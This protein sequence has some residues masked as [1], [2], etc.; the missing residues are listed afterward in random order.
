M[1]TYEKIYNA[2]N[3]VYKFQFVSPAEQNFTFDVTGFGGIEYG[4]E[5]P[6]NEDVLYPSTIEIKIDDYDNINYV[7]LFNLRAS[8]FDNMN[9]F[10]FDFE[11]RFHLKV[12]KDNVQIYFGKL[13]SIEKELK[14]EEV[15][16]TFSD[17]LTILKGLSWWN[18]SVSDYLADSA[19]EIG[20]EAHILERESVNVMIGLEQTTIPNAVGF[21]C[22]YRFDKPDP[23]I[24]QWYLFRD[25]SPEGR[26]C[27]FGF[28]QFLHTLYK[29]LRSSITFSFYHSWQVDP[30]GSI[31][32]ISNIENNRFR[33]ANLAEKIFGYYII[34]PKTDREQSQVPLNV[35]M[36]YFELKQTMTING[37]EYETWADKEDK[38]E[39]PAREKYDY[40]INNVLKHLAGC[41]YAKTGIL[42]LNQAYFIQKNYSAS[43]T[44]EYI[45]LDEEA[46][47]AEIRTDDPCFDRVCVKSIDL[48]RPDEHTEGTG[49]NVKTYEIDYDLQSDEG[50]AWNN[51]A[52]L[53]QDNFLYGFDSVNGQ[54]FYG[55]NTTSAVMLSEYYYDNNTSESRLWNIKLER[56]DQNFID[57]LKLYKILSV[58]NQFDYTHKIRPITMKKEFINNKTIIEGKE[59][60]FE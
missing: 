44:T 14:D 42:D 49:A 3:G 30:Q 56:V 41:F 20:S 35:W 47:N 2:V 1:A 22:F 51:F 29:L 39:V 32:G 45:V 25:M 43:P 40:K 19:D 23:N 10:P 12:F 5:D 46:E 13:E 34:I 27:N 57:V 4:Y 36:E 21:N 48:D 33:I 6:N 54:G 58:N 17:G 15:T 50:V 8:Y 11:S 16:L 37:T 9:T 38:R 24:N 31:G 52:W 60:L 18:K 55:A 28:K 7:K 59:Y 26:T 53:S